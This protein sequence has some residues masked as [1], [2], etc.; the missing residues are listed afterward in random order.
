MENKIAV[1]EKQK[2]KLKQDKLLLMRDNE[3]L[4]SR[5]EEKRKQK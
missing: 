2:T 4:E 3:E 5:I 1:L